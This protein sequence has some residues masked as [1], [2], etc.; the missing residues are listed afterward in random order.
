MSTK[1]AYPQT[2]AVPEHDDLETDLKAVLEKHL[3]EPVAP[4]RAAASAPGDAPAGAIDP[5]GIAALIQ[6]FMTIL[7]LFKKK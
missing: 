2:F 7:S 4:A 3:G 5:A 1:P 6:A